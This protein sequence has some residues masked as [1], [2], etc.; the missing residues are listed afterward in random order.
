MKGIVTFILLFVSIGA[1]CQRNEVLKAFEKYHINRTA[2]DSLTVHA[3]LR[4]NFDL[5]TTIITEG[6]EKVYRARHDARK[7]GDS[8]WTLLTVNNGSAS[9]LDKST[10]DKQ[11]NSKIPNLMPDTSSYKIIKDDGKELVVGY[12][13]DPASM[14]DD[15][16]FMTACQVKL[17]FDAASGKLLRSEGSIDSPFKI[18]MFRANYMASTTTY[19]WEPN[20]QFYLPL[21]EEVSINLS[22]L[23]KAV[24]MITTNEYSN[25]QQP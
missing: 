5:T 2:I 13:Y 24:D 22:I 16:K 17:F 7:T 15:N 11:H 3:E 20:T 12:K 1:F 9:H 25:F 4:F 19:Q 10:F 23:G 14:I 8:A 18:K 21:K 6:S